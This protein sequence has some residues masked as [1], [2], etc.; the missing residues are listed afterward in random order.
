M[1][2]MNRAAR[3]GAKKASKKNRKSNGRGRSRARRKRNDGAMAS[4]SKTVRV[5]KAIGIVLGAA[6]LGT[7]VMLLVSMQSFGLSAMAQAGILIAAGVIVASAGVALGYPIFGI[8]AATG[9]TTVGFNYLALSWGA[10]RAANDL[11]ARVTA[12]GSSTP[13]Q[14]ASAAPAATQLPAPAAPA[15]AAQPAGW[16]TG[17]PAWPAGLGHSVGYGNFNNFAAAPYASSFG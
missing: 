8:A 1:A 16:A 13:A 14:T 17:T 9:F 12:L 7:G 6:V 11:V 15:A 10:S 2:K 4:G 5:L 3:R